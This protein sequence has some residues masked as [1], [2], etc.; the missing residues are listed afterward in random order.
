MANN[1][2]MKAAG[3]STIAWGNEMRRFFLRMTV[4]TS[5]F[6]ELFSQN[7]LHKNVARREH[8]R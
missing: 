4:G 7:R 2:H 6:S 5:S 3:N 1:Y 8:T